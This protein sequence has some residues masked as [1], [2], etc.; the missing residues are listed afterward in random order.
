MPLIIILI[1]VFFLEVMSLL[2]K[3]RD[4]IRV[5]L[6]VELLFW[7]V[8]FIASLYVITAL[9]LTFLLNFETL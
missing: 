2:G 3:L 9:T 6:I 4:N 7:G 8:W 1:F 5:A